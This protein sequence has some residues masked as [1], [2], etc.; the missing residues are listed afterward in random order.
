[1]A[2]SYPERPVGIDDDT[3]TLHKLG[4]A[5]ELF[6]AMGGFSNFAISFTII[7]VLS[8]CV[9]LYPL[10]PINGGYTAA[11]IGWRPTVTRTTM[12]YWLSFSQTNP[13]WMPHPSSIYQWASAAGP[14]CWK[15][16]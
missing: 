14:A 2:E 11:S 8:G 1:M 7:S 10:I 13:G 15:A 4:Y 16:S 12:G 6:R 9:T 3:R 5:Q